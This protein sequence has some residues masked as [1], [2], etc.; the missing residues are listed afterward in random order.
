M[1]EGV[2]LTVESQQLT[3]IC[4]HVSTTCFDICVGCC[5]CWMP[6]LRPVT[7]RGAGEAKPPMENFSP[8]LE[9]CVRH[10]LKVLDIVQKIWA[11]LRKLFAPPGVPS[12]LRSCPD[13][14]KVRKRIFFSATE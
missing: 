14:L 1:T 4:P 7:R 3:S 12:C 2:V 10:R 9:K 11:P 6:W 8:L 13:Y 5:L